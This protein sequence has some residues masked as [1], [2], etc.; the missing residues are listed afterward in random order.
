MKDIFMFFNR[1]NRISSRVGRN[2][3]LFLFVLMINEEE[4][5]IISE[6]NFKLDLSMIIDFICYCINDKIEYLFNSGNYENTK[7]YI[8][9]ALK[10]FKQYGHERITKEEFNKF[11]ERESDL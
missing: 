4:N 6:E 5:N 11:M 2:K 10:T 8:I 3:E 9:K 7:N 1:L